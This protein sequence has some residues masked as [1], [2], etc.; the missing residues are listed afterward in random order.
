MFSFVKK[1][2]FEV[3]KRNCVELGVKFNWVRPFYLFGEGQPEKSLIPSIVRGF[4]NGKLPSLNFIDNH[5]DLIHIDDAASYIHLL[6]AESVEH[7]ILNIGS[8]EPTDIRITLE[9]IVSHFNLKVDIASFYGEKSAPQK[10]FWA[11]MSRWK[12]ITGFKE[13]QPS[14]PLQYILEQLDSLK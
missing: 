5:I 13:V 4:K 9:K 11:D 2:A 6:C 10:C 12:N 1:I 8:G 7:E 14:K 3:T